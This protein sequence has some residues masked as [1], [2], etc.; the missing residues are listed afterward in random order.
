MIQRFLI[1][2]S[3][4]SY[5]I[6]NFDVILGATTYNGE[7]GVD[8]ISQILA[9]SGYTHERHEVVTSD[10]YIITVHRIPPKNTT[11]NAEPAVLMHGIIG[12]GADFILPG[13]NRGLGN[14]LHDQGY[15]V[16]LPSCRG[17]TWSKRHRNLS[18][19]SPEYWDFSWH[20]IGVYDVAAI[21]DFVTNYTGAEK[22]HYTSHSQGST[23]LMVLLSE[24]PEYNSKIASANLLAPIAFLKNLNSPILRFVSSKTDEL[25]V[26]LSNLGIYELLGTSALNQI[27][28]RLFCDSGSPSQD[29]CILLMYTVVGFSGHNIDRALLPK[30]Y[31]TTPAGVSTKQIIHFGQLIQSG[32]F[33]Q[34][35]YRSRQNNYR[36]YKRTTPPE[37]NLKNVQVPI[38]MFYGGQDFLM[39]RQ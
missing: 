7:V 9:S 2:V 5:V 36:L 25:E 12:S 34:Y 37:Y 23:V 13:R 26:L 32:K 31:E 11:F 20:E 35:D 33:Q 10:G 22:V 1:I 24:R 14:I 6:L 16:W 17:T 3:V 19:T 21:L 8:L 27:V 28:A 4:T 30:I 18:V 38:Q 39:S 15:D 29:L